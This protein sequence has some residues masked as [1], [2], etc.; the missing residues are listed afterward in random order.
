MAVPE[1]IFELT[2]L[3]KLKFSV[4]SGIDCVVS[5]KIGHVHQLQE[6]EIVGTFAN[7]LPDEIGELSPLEKLKINC[8]Y[9]KKL[10]ESIGKL[11]N[12]K[13][14]RCYGSD[15]STIILDFFSQLTSLH[16]LNLA[17]LGTGHIP[18]VLF[19]MPF[20]QTLRFDSDAPQGEIEGLKKALPNREVRKFR[21]ESV[22]GFP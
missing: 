19:E 22:S 4:K 10:P 9:L 12:L 11:Q 20:L 7:Y 18:E 14:L 6:L 5:P 15:N 13:E 8:L 21:K 16:L 1:P 3:K 2:N 17:S